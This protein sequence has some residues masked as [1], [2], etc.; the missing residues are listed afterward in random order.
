VPDRLA[1]VRLFIMGRN[2]W[3]QAESWP[4]AGT[5]YIPYY[6]HSDGDAN[7]RLGG[8]GLSVTMP[9]DERPDQFR[10][11]PADPVPYCAG[12]D[13]RQVGGPDDFAET[14]LRQDI[15]CYTGPLLTDTL[16]I[17][18][19]LTVRLFAA[20]SAP[21]TDWTA[22][23]LDVWPDGRAIRLN[24]GAVRARFRGGEEARLLT[25]GGI[26]SYLIDCWATCIELPAGH[27]LRVEISSSAFGKI[28]RNLNGGGPIGQESEP[29]I[30][31]QTVHHD[32]NHPSHL[33]VPVLKAW[34]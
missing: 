21:D 25:P 33:L 27:R 10:Y 15:L 30:A 28:D 4:V 16:R 24:D 23:I 3:M 18:G 7:S 6:F 29:V 26:E 9:G 2:D 17:C 22:K 34:P 13:W 8:G 31:E 1:P 32:R 12:L 19:P 14:E 5:A 11:D 20:S